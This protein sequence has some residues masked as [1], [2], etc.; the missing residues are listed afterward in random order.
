[1]MA[2]PVGCCGL[3]MAILNKSARFDAELRELLVYMQRS[4]ARFDTGMIG[5]LVLIR[6]ML[7]EHYLLYLITMTAFIIRH[8]LQRCL[9][10]IESF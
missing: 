1:M 3:A 10:I 2:L 5:S 6:L 9:E 7:P 8:T 4:L